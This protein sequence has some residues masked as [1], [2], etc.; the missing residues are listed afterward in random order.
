MMSMHQKLMPRRFT[1]ESGAMSRDFTLDEAVSSFAEVQQ[2]CLEDVL[3]NTV[4]D[5]LQAVDRTVLGYT[6]LAHS[7]YAK[8]QRKAQKVAKSQNSAQISLGKLDAATADKIKNFTSIETL[9]ENNSIMCDCTDIVLPF[10][11]VN[12]PTNN[13][14]LRSDFIARLLE[15]GSFF[16]GLL[17]IAPYLHMYAMSQNRTVVKCPKL[18]L[19]DDLLL[20]TSTIF[21]KLPTWSLALD[22]TGCTTPNKDN[23]AITGISVTRTYCNLGAHA[24]I[25]DTKQAS[26][27]KKF[28]PGQ[29]QVK[30][31]GKSQGAHG[32]NSAQADNE[33]FNGLS[34]MLCNNNQT[35]SEFKILFRL[36]P[37]LTVDEMLVE[38][39]LFNDE[40]RKEIED[41][42]KKLNQI[43]EFTEVETP[44][45]KG[46]VMLPEDVLQALREAVKYVCYVITHLSNLSE[47]LQNHDVF[48]GNA[49]QT[50]EFNATA[51]IKVIELKA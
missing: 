22:L 45:G 27:H 43:V 14:K 20:N 35:Y 4:G 12:A 11:Q 37:E 47:P 9:P 48:A 1:K 51:P 16:D 29:A 36:D 3:D 31:Q 33:L 26:K 39:V 6:K 46:F 19:S 24:Q 32:Q 38:P 13:R 40:G 44:E 25:S 7:Q 17:E 34:I 30:G 10:M 23:E 41:E 8:A 2:V 21:Q 5:E 18:E 50:F 42:A 28:V 15:N 49:P